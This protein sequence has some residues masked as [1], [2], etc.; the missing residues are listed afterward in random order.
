MCGSLF[1]GVDRLA[2]SDMDG[3]ESKKGKAWGELFFLKRRRH[4]LHDASPSPFS[5]EVVGGRAQMPNLPNTAGLGA[6]CKTKRRADKCEW[7]LDLCS[8]GK[9]SRG[10]ARCQITCSVSSS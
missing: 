1:K 2:V 7:G 4:P 3:S 10:R 8:V 5:K 9:D 6:P